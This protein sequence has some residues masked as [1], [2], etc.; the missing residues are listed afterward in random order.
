VPGEKCEDFTEKTPLCKECVHRRRIDGFITCEISGG[1]PYARDN[2]CEN[3]VIK[4]LKISPEQNFTT[5][6]NELFSGF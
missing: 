3:L 1:Y 6:Q 4:E 2:Q 5:T